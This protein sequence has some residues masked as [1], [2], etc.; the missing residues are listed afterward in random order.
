MVTCVFNFLSVYH[1]QPLRIHNGYLYTGSDE[2]MAWYG[3]RFFQ[4]LISWAM[5]SLNSTCVMLMAI[6]MQ[7][8][9]M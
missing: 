5:S 8:L 4:K 7:I 6:T 9:M 2:D 3:R 1:L